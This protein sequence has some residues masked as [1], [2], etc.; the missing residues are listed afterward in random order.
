MRSLKKLA[1]CLRS[2]WSDH[3]GNVAVYWTLAA[4][5][6]ILGVG[7]AIDV[8]RAY[9]VRERLYFALDAAGLAVGSSEGT[10][11]EMEAVMQAYFDANYPAQALG[12]PAT[13]ILSMV[14][15]NGITTITVS[16]E[17]EVGTTFTRVIGIDEITVGSSIEVIQETEGLE[18]ALVLDVTG[19][20]QGTKIA[21]LRNASLDL[22]G[23]LFGDDTE[24]E[25]LK[26]AIV[27]YSAAVNVGSIAPSL[28]PS[29]AANYD[30]SDE[31]A[32][33][34]CV[35][36]RSYP[37]D[38]RD[39]SEADG[40]P[41]RRF[42]Y[43]QGYDNNWPPTDNSES[44]G[45]ERRSPNLAC[46]NA[47][48]P[49][50]NQRAP[51]ENT[52]NALISWHRGGT[53]SNVGMV[54]GWRVI[55]PDAPFTEA[56]PYGTPKYDKV[57]VLM[58][59]GVNGYYTVGSGDYTGELEPDQDPYISD[60]AAYQRVDDGELGTTS[61]NT[62]RTVMNNRL[63]EVCDEMAALDI[64]IYTVT[65]QLSDT[66]TLGIYERCAANGGRHFDSPTPDDLREDFREIADEL[67]NLRISR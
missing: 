10:Q 48:V 59:D 31:E 37:H 2:L 19:S 43:P 1:D 17:A 50:T 63:E 42:E 38:S 15:T 34:G 45:N 27:P 30:P 7:V 67:K 5:P 49:L 55:S 24:K 60:Y 23:V 52:I 41:W 62:T 3:R 58:T 4:V 20:M 64:I 57:V 36:A 18:L 35:L 56:L 12:V 32:W 66:N 39:S 26:V 54:W 11:A 14:E 61:K 40:G 22:I 51:L 46:P 33:K 44:T 9:F 65:F 8:S 16:G 28:V 29:E 25:F 6:V 47:I 21:A 13:P 53:F